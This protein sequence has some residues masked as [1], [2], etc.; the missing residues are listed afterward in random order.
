MCITRVRQQQ[1]LAA[2]QKLSLVLLVISLLK[3]RAAPFF[4]DC[5]QDMSQPGSLG[6]QPSALLDCLSQ[7][8]E[9]VWAQVLLPKLRE[10]GSAVAV[11]LT[12]SRLR[13]LCYASHTCIELGELLDTMEP[14]EVQA[15][16][17]RL[18]TLCRNLQVV[19]LHMETEDRYHDMP[20]IL[21]ALAR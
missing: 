7:L 15:R 16:L 11:A 3:L 21:P 17:H 1:A 14:N 4:V 8:N 13:D 19:A 5:I 20:S 2:Q 18:P 6:P 12:C 10:Q 9:D